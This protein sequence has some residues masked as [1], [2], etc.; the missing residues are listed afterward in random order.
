[1]AVAVR[2]TIPPLGAAAGA[3]KVVAAPLAVWAGLKEP[4]LELP[5]ATVQST[6]ASD[7]SLV[8][9]AVNIAVAPACKEAGGAW[10]KAMVIGDGAMVTM[11]CTV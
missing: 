2:V 1:M 8:T 7:G 3:V 9:V 5:Q 11:A 10:V 6:P 4:Q